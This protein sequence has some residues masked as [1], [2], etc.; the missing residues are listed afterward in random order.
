MLQKKKKKYQ[1]YID[2]ISLE[3]YEWLRSSEELF[4]KYCIQKVYIAVKHLNPFFIITYVHNKYM[5]CFF[6][7][8]GTYKFK[9]TL[10]PLLSQNVMYFSFTSSTELKSSF[11]LRETNPEYRTRRHWISR[12]VQIV[13]LMP[14]KTGKTGKAV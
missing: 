1:Q 14:I 9:Y 6:G 5:E 11:P 10:K 8:F 4:K 12:R 2:H 13:S 7:K 3:E